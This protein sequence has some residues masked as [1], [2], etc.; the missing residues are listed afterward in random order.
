[1]WLL[2]ALL[3]LIFWGIWGVVT[4]VALINS[5][6]YHYYVYGSVVTFIAVGILSLVFRDKLSIGFTD[7]KVILLASLLGVLGYI[8]FVLAMNSG[9]AS[10][11]V[12][13]TALYPVITV[14][15]GVLLLKES[16]STT[17]WI[18]IA[19]AIIAIILISLES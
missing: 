11:V 17:Q 2:Y 13:L 15:L 16:V 4:K 19:L 6:W 3:S 14:I 1:M 10:I 9:K 12:P 18:G 8:F 7:I 5:E